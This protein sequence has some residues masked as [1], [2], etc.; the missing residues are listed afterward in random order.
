MIRWKSKHL[1]SE[2][3]LGGVEH[4]VFTWAREMVVA[5]GLG[6]W[7][8]VPYG[9]NDWCSRAMEKIDQIFHLPLGSRVLEDL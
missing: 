3:G 8:I 6:K 5:G 9:S 2:R 4:G 1:S 7:A